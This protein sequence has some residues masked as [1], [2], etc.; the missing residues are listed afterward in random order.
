M[1]LTKEKRDKLILVILIIVVGVA[2]LWFGLISYQQQRLRDLGDR[3]QSAL[4]KLAQ[5]E[6][7]IK[8]A[9]Q[10]EAELATTGKQLAVLEEEM[11]SGD[12][13]L[14]I[15]NNLR[16][17]KL[18]YKVEIPQ[19]SQPEVKEMSLLPKFPYKQVTLTVGGT[20]YYHD[21]GKFL[22][23]FENEFSHFRVL[24]LDLEPTPAAMGG[25]REKLSFKMDIVTLIKPGAS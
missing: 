17:F 15:V 8:N 13:Y 24:N 3:K 19:F 12:V 4:T 16:R 5:V 10:V 9:D 23:D 21:F 2:G 7:A 14:W 20:A 18:P 6:Q 1:K 22:A 11:A 25:D